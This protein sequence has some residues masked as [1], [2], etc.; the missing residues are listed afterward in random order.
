MVYPQAGY[1]YHDTLLEIYPFFNTLK[2]SSIPNLLTVSSNIRVI[3]EKSSSS[4][5]WTCQ[6]QKLE[7]GSDAGRDTQRTALPLL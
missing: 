4:F 7:L 2:N 3:R 1:T 6:G 5:S